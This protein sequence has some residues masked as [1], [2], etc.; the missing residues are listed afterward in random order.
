MD[1]I[2]IKILQLLE[3]K[4]RLSHEELSK[5]LHI[6]RP[7]VHQRVAK[8]EK[9]N[10]IKGYRCIVDW[11]KLEQKLKVL[12][13]VKMK[14]QNFKEIAGKIVD[15]HV[16][17]ATILECQRLAG[18]WCMMLKVRVSSPEDITNLIDEMVKFPDVQETST[19]FVLS[20]LYENGMKEN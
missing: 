4:G 17:G 8:L 5:L 7:A 6:S 2:D 10:I 16:P 11:S 12:I 15:L 14:C 20:T 3:E 1:D 13:F 9:S 19:T 18:E